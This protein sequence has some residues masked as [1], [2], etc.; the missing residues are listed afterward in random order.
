[1]KDTVIFDLDGTL[2]LI[3]HRKHF[4]E[5]DK[6]DQDWDAFYEGCDK[7]DPNPDIFELFRNLTDN[8]RDPENEKDI[9]KVLIFSGRSEVVR[10]KTIIWLRSHTG[11][12]T[13][14]L[15]GILKMRP[16]G[17]FTPDDELKKKWAEEL[18]IHRIAMVFDDRDKVVKMWRSLGLTCLQ[19]AEGNF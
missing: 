11:F 15:N 18:G 7:D 16:A 19:V 9:Y 17:D 12:G 3:G 6:K 4:V 10:E 2:A 14:Y 1:M 8:T 5:C 13:D